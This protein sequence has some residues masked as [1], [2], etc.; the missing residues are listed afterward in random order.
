MAPVTIEV[1]KKPVSVDVDEH[2]RVQTTLEGLAKASDSLTMKTFIISNIP[3]L[4][5]PSFQRFSRKTERSRPEQHLAFV[6]VPEQS[7]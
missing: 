6:T 5:L 4:L 2:P 3:I 7:F 1:K